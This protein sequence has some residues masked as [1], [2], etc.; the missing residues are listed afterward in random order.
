MTNPKTHP[1]TG[2][3]VGY[4]HRFRDAFFSSAKPR[5]SWLE[6]ITENYFPDAENRDTLA[7][8]SLR[9]LRRDFPVSLHGIGL[10]LASVDPLSERYLSRLAGLVAEIDPWLVTDHLCWTGVGH[11]NL[12]D[13]LPFPFTRESLDHVAERVSRVQELLRRPLAVENLTYYAQPTGDE[14]RETAFLNELCRRTGCRLLLDVNNIFV[15]AQNLGT[16]AL[17][18]LHGLDLKNVAEMHVAGHT[19]R[20]DGLLIDTHGAPVRDEVWRLYEAALALAGPVPTLIERDQNIPEWAEMEA[21]LAQLR[22]L[23]APFLRKGARG[24]TRVADL[25]A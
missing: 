4:R 9:A 1:D 15:N 3:G 21:E 5:V 16:D 22:S 14:L 24:V 23:R 17:G 8:Q 6:V 12:F 2:I 19:A 10:N 13:L 20:R 11:E 18:Y 7:R 25:R